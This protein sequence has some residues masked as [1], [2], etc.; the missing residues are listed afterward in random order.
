MEF[1]G[2]HISLYEMKYTF[3]CIFQ[4]IR[5]SQNQALKA[6]FTHSALQSS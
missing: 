2:G 4:G 5:H 1:C 6:N 3:N